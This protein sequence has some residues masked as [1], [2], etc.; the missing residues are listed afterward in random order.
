LSESLFGERAAARA[1]FY[2]RGPRRSLYEIISSTINHARL[3]VFDVDDMLNY[4]HY[5]MALW[6]KQ[7]DQLGDQPVQQEYLEKMRVLAKGI[8]HHFN[9]GGPKKVG[10]ILMVFPFGVPDDTHRCNYMSNADR[11]DVIKML[12]EQIGYFEKQVEA[13]R[14]AEYAAHK[15]PNPFFDR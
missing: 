15:E 2:R 13:E 6:G 8:D 9:G 1:R 3:N 14:A 11:V 10:F 7:K 12:K 5:H 4:G